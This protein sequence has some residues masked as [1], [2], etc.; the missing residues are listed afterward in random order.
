M[1]Y[2][3]NVKVTVNQPVDPHYQ[4]TTS[5][6]CTCVLARATPGENAGQPTTIQGSRTPRFPHATSVCRR[7]LTA[8][9]QA[10]LTQHNNTQ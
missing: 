3:I 9:V 8:T 6:L 7:T 1:T 4:R 2:T 10:V 5:S